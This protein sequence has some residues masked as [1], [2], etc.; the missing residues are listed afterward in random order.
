M[1]WLGV[2]ACRVLQRG[3]GSTKAIEQIRNAEAGC[4]KLS[5]CHR[6]SSQ[7]Q[8]SPEVQVAKLLNERYLLKTI[9]RNPTALHAPY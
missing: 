5:K 8:G 3:Q 9:T 7:V 6:G 4:T 1:A 2:A